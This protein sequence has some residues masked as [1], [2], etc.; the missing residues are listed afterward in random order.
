MA[1]TTSRTMKF[2][3]M[4][5]LIA[6]LMVL[7]GCGSEPT[8]K[9]DP[10]KALD[11]Y[12]QLGLGYLASG[13]K[14]QA[15]QNLLRAINIDADSL[16]ANDAIALLYQSDGELELAE[17]HF[18]NTLK[19]DKNFTQARNN[20][21]RFLYM[22]NRAEEARDNYKVATQDVNYRLRPQAFI[23]LAL[24]EKRL[25]NLGAAEAALLRSISLNPRAGTA[26][27]EMIELKIEQQDYVTAKGYLDR[28]ENISQPT[29]RSLAFGLSL[30]EKFGNADQLQSY[31]M[32]L[33]SL[34]PTSR[35]A[36]QLILSEQS[37]PE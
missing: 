2:R 6:S 13:N 26:V 20:Y 12:V 30:A 27:L 17:K 21:A 35:E 7:Q 14:E 8:R 37:T 19:I 16:I 23:G 29:P 11:N 1:R 5:L 10:E 25:G 15:R 36:R 4:M 24:S 3:L 9:G 32:T 31:S 33:K 34:F 28:F 22:N 18:K